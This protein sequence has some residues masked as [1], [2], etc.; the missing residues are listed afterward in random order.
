M[1]MCDQFQEWNVPWASR[2]GRFENADRLV[3][4]L[5]TNTAGR[6]QLNL[7][8][9]YKGHASYRSLTYNHLPKN[10]LIRSASLRSSEMPRTIKTICC[11]VWIPVPDT[12][13]AEGQVSDFS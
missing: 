10:V 5:A 3:V 9:R 4:V 1:A 11:A 13:R 8:V 7:R 12:L 6:L 2:Q